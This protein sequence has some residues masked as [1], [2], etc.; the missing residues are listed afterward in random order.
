MALFGGYLCAT[1]VRASVW[2]IGAWSAGIFMLLSYKRPFTAFAIF[3]LIALTV[4]LSS[5]SIISG[6]SAMIG[7]GILLVLV[8]ASRLMIN[9]TSFV[10]IKEYRILV[11]LLIIV[12]LSLLSNFN[13]LMD[14]GRAFTYLQL[15]LLI[16]LIVNFTTTGSQLKALGYIVVAS[17]VLLAAIVILNQYGLLPQG[18]VKLAY[19]SLSDPSDVIARS[20]GLWGDPNFTAVQLTVAIPFLIEWMLG[21]R[22]R[23]VRLPLAGAMG[24]ILFA[25]SYTFSTGGL[26]GLIAML[27][28]KATLNRQRNPLITVGRI[29]LIAAIGLGFLALILPGSFVERVYEKVGVVN[30]YA[31]TQ[32]YELLLQ[33]GTNRGDTWQAAI[34]AIGEAPLVGHGP[35][36]SEHTIARYAINIYKSNLAAHNMFL[37]VG[38][39]LGIPGLVVFVILI[40]VAVLAVKPQTRNNSTRSDPTLDMT[41]RGLYIALIAFCIQGLAL[42]IQNMKLLWVLI[43]MAIVYK[44]LTKHESMQGTQDMHNL[45]ATS[46]P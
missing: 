16:V 14:L 15:P 27:L 8:W 39:D 3:I 26:V 22:S 37:L 18:L 40:V 28:L 24:L 29:I 34:Q 38:S 21:V 20:G 31:K 7:L 42:D 23:I 33:V 5:I 2:L 44:Q 9:S 10:R 1:D 12:I 45:V 4:W 36:N 30:D 13:G 11:V 46:I 6:L 43:G 35:G 25:F 19:D 41:S 32:D 17:S